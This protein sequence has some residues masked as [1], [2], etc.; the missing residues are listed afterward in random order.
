MSNDDC[1]NC[2]KDGKSDLKLELF[3]EYSPNTS[4]ASYTESLRKVFGYGEYQSKLVLDI[5]KKN[6]SVSIYESTRD[7][8]LNIT[9]K[10]ALESIPHR[11][12]T[13]SKIV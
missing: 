2:K 3:L 4:D 10:L 1:G 13:V 5:A 8:V 7:D 12:E 9:T 11:V 6:G